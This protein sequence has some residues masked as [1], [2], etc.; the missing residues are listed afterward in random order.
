MC[1]R[2]TL[3]RPRLEDI[4]AELD[5]DFD[6][7]DAAR[8]RARYNVAPTDLHWLLVAGGSTERPRIVPAVWGLPSSRQK[9][10]INVKAETLRKGA[11]RS[12]RHAVAIADGFYEWTGAAKARKPL[13]FH[14]ASGQLLL[15]AAVDTPLEGGSARAPVAFSIITVPPGAE[16]AAVHD[17]QPAILEPAQLGAWLTGGAVDAGLAVLQTSPSG[18]LEA[19][20]VS[21]RVN[22]VANDDAECLMA[23]PSA[24]PPQQ[25]SRQLSLLDR[26]D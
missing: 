21:S 9:P 2:I 12:R 16:V 10:V 20:A 6:A 3:T 14:R 4:A 13:W 17:R 15:L 7:D 25:R 8:Y 1:G 5:A 11:F 19:R 26:D 23:A 24:P 18:T 22:S